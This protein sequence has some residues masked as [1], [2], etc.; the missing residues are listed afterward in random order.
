MIPD[1]ADAAIDK[2]LSARAQKLVAVPAELLTRPSVPPRNRADRSRL[3][4]LELN[5]HQRSLP[6]ND[7]TVTG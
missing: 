7:F 6:P 3:R 2:K 5:T 1:L 4:Q